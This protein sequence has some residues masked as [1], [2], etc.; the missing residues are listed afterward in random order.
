M[1]VESDDEKAIEA[2]S[3]N[4]RQKPWYLNN[5]CSKHMTSDKM[6]FLSFKKSKGGS[7]NFGNNEKT[8]IIG[9]DMIG[10]HNFAKIED[11]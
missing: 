9:K 10:K 7:L 4:A 1:D 11:V 3:Q 6:W 2:S 5:G 8:H